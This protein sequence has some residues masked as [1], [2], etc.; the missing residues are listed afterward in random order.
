MN[1]NRTLILN[2]MKDSE[3]L[4]IAKKTAIKAGNA[5]MEIYESDFE[6]RMK[7]SSPVTDADIATN[8]IITDE[9]KETAAKRIQEL[10]ALQSE[11]DPPPWD[12]EQVYPDLLNTILKD[13]LKA[14]GDWMKT[15]LTDL[16]V[17]EKMSPQKCHQLLN[18]LN[19]P[20]A[21]L[22]PE[23]IKQIAEMKIYL[24]K[25]LDDSKVEGLLVRFGEL[26]L[27][28]QRQFLDIAQK[29]IDLR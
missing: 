10:L 28:L 16:S 23:H 7:E 29:F 1:L 27:A 13:R 15:V 17:I 25:R 18:R 6:V 22:E 11:D 12:V 4:D 2:K 9:L 26:S 14:A 3:L 19:P 24:E 20:P 5:I 21:Y 8:K